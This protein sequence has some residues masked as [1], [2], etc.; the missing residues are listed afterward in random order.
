MPFND[1]DLAL[2]VFKSKIPIISAIGHETDITIIDF[3]SDIRASTP[4][5]AAEKSV[6]IKTELSKSVLSLTQR[7]SNSIQNK[8]QTID[9]SFL[10]LSKFLKAPNLIINSYRDKFNNINLV[11]SK[12]VNNIY[13]YNFNQLKNFFKLLRTPII[14]FENH[15]KYLKKLTKDI[16][17]AITVKHKTE[18]NEY[19]KFNRLLESNSL[20]TNLKKGFSI[21]RKNKKI[22]SNS[23]LIT[24][25]ELLN[26]QFLDKSINVKVKKIS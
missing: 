10:N 20:H 3:V 11:L 17:R 16:N 19:S 25:D 21:I 22:I 12:E 4:T 23:K 24:N 9:S 13:D 2:A 18:L 6:P 8:F 7:L 14:A 5:A 1:E 26:I 15:E